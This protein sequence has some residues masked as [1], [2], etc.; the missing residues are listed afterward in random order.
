MTSIF[1][2]MIPSRRREQKRLREEE[3]RLREQREGDVV[4]SAPNDG[5]WIGN[6]QTPEL[7]WSSPSTQ[8]CFSPDTAN[9]LA[10]NS[11]DIGEDLFGEE[12][13]IVDTEA[14]PSAQ[15]YRE[16]Q[17]KSEKNAITITIP[18][19]WPSRKT[20]R[21]STS[22]SQ[23]KI[24]LSD[25]QHRASPVPLSVLSSESCVTYKQ[26]PTQYMR[27][28]GSR[29]RGNS[30]APLA[31]H[32]IR[33]AS[34]T[35]AVEL[36]F[37]Q[38]N[39]LSAMGLARRSPS[40]PAD[41]EEGHNISAIMLLSPVVEDFPSRPKASSNFSRR[42]SLRHIEHPSRQLPTPPPERPSTSHSIVARSETG[43]STSKVTDASNPTSTTQQTTRSSSRGPGLER[44]GMMR[45]TSREPSSRRAISHE[46]KERRAFS[47]EPIDRR[48]MSREP[49]HRR[50]ISREPVNRRALSREPTERRAVSR[51][52]VNR[53]AM[54]QAPAE[55]RALSREPVNRRAMSREPAR[56]RAMTGDHVI[57]QSISLEEL[58]RFASPRPDRTSINSESSKETSASEAGRKTSNRSSAGEG[59]CASC[60]GETTANEVGRKVFNSTAAA[61]GSYHTSWADEEA[62]RKPSGSSAAGGSYCASLADEASA[63][64]PERNVSNSSAAGGSYYTSLAN[65]YRHI[66]R[67]AS[68]PPDSDSVVGRVAK[69]TKEKPKEK[70]KEN[71][72]LMLVSKELVPG[73]ADLYS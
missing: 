34:P 44:T 16:E 60:A 50:A 14:E 55:R 68:K 29:S 48:A 65:E 72:P 18:L 62:A 37:R 35:Q 24:P 4:I 32:L 59:Y 23:I 33:H 31:S 71:P 52:P 38:A 21:R 28:L 2:S 9:T 13:V 42:D 20:H 69:V 57:H 66:A 46:P 51:E 3:K 27:G 1:D 58:R 47:R 41:L 49:T 5:C 64:D 54:S 10:H 26:T 53:R 6:E 25:V 15:P 67:E 22:S 19:P 12:V 45:S 40:P 7:E 70:E 43:S 63:R 11:P 36:P 56:R 73:G 17:E 8:G 30:P 61:G 39:P